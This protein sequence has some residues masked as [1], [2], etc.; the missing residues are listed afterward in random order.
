MRKLIL[1][2]CLLAVFV[3]AVGLVGCDSSQTPEQ[4]AKAFFEAYEN[5]DADAMWDMMSADTRKTAGSKANMEEEM[6]ESSSKVKFTVGEVTVN[7]DSATAELAVTAS[8]QT[9]TAAVPLVKE[10]GVWK[11]DSASMTN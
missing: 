5:L 6:K 2:V 8:G 9:M 1:T 7:G 11:V 10:D 3:S 4:V